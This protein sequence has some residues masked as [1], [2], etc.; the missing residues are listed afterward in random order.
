[1]NN[2]L[3]YCGLIDAIIN[4][5]DKNLPVPFNSKIMKKIVD[6]EFVK[7]C[8]ELIHSVAGLAEKCSFSKH[9]CSIV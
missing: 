7:T 8:D 9:F 5:C 3:S 2:L 6:S 1:M 4:A